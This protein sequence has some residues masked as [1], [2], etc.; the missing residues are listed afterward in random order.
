MAQV[1][2]T[3]IKQDFV[4]VRDLV[5]KLQENVFDDMPMEYISVNYLYDIIDDLKVTQ[6]VELDIQLT[7]SKT[8]LES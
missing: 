2:K 4:K 6:E 5:N 8:K 7:D 1:S 3:T